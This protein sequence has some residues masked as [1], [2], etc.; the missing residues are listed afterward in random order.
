MISP[1]QAVL[2]LD[3]Y[4]V[5]QD[6]SLVKLNQNE[7]SYDVPAALKQDILNRL[8]E[9][10]WN[11]YP[12][13]KADSLVRAISAYTDYPASGIVVGNGSNEMIQAVLAAFC[14]PG[15]K[16][17]LVSPGFSIY[18]RV[19]HI[20][21]LE[22]IDVPLADDFAFDTPR[23]IEK[24]EEARMIM[25]ASPNNPTGTAFN[26]DDIEEIAETF[27][28][29]FV[30][31]EAYFE[32]HKVTAQTCIS[33]YQNIILL[34]TLSKAFSLAGLRL[35]YVLAAPEMARAMD[36]T[37]LPFSVGIFQQIAGEV[38]LNNHGVITQVAD[39]II[40][41]R[42]KVFSQLSRMES[43]R[44]IPSSTNF[45]LFEVKDGSAKGVFDACYHQGVLLRYFGGKHLKDFLR[46]TIGTPEE[47]EIFVTTLKEVVN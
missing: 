34:R 15:D 9:W 44:P 25:I 14:G 22:R 18:P 20:M 37:K 2:D 16:V 19:A 30:I 3:E 33:R 1:K 21:G 47:N 41:E 12:P 35:G 17:L 40:K 31:D 28:G 4:C 39:M 24:S 36:K 27:H 46:V 29:I 13:L 32:F 7:S 26:L 8:N 11:R 42:E 10:K 6:Q 43:I 45:I 38:L 5:P 23:I